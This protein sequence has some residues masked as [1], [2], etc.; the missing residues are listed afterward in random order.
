MSLSNTELKEIIDNNKEYTFKL[1]K[2]GIKECVVNRRRKVGIAIFISFENELRSIGWDYFP[3]KACYMEHILYYVDTKEWKNKFKLDER[4]GS[5]KN[6]L[7]QSKFNEFVNNYVE[8]YDTSYD[9]ALKE[10]INKNDWEEFYYLGDDEYYNKLVDEEFDKF[11]NTFEFSI[12]KD[13]KVK[14]SGL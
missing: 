12:D 5:I 4:L 8:E 13:L 1:V 3:S 9:V 10:C 2:E 14:I 6:R 7:P 11:I